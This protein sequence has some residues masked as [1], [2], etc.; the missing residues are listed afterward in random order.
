MIVCLVCSDASHRLR[1][2][3]KRIL[4]IRFH[5]FRISH[6]IADSGYGF[7]CRGWSLSSMRTAAFAACSMLAKTPAPSLPVNAVPN[8]ASVHFG[9]QGGLPVGAH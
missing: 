7:L 5:R 2:P 6:T 4:H 1:E 9:L 8:D 3:S